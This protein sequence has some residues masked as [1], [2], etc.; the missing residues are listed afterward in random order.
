V[1]LPHTG[2]PH[3]VLGINSRRFIVV[4]R[5]YNFIICARKYEEKR[6]ALASSLTAG[7][8][9]PHSVSFQARH[10]ALREASQSGSDL[11]LF[12]ESWS[13]LCH[14]RCGHGVSSAS[15]A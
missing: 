11:D 9:T 6:E 15:R 3:A 8:H 14:L 2:P 10:S 13:R 12:D 7:P 5:A 4:Q 1:W